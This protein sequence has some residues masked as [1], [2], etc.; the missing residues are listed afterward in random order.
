MSADTNQ[1]EIYLRY[2]LLNP[3]YKAYERMRTHLIGKH[4]YDKFR[5]IQRNV[6]KTFASL[7]SG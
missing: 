6:F 1:E 7:C 5:E 2:A 4:G 3:N